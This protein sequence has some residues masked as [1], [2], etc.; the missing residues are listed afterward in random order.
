[1]AAGGAL[2]GGGPG[3]GPVGL[4][5]GAKRDNDVGIVTSNDHSY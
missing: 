4:G 1:M 5:W 2:P 3:W